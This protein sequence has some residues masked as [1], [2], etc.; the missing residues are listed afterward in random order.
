MKA[1]KDEAAPEAAPEQ[2]HSAAPIDPRLVRRAQATKTYMISGVVVGSLTAVLVLTQAKLLSNSI[3]SVFSTHTLNG[4]G[5]TL[6][7]LAAVLVGRGVLAWASSWLAQRTSAAVKSQLRNDILSARLAAPAHQ[8]SSSSTLVTLVTQ[9]LD[10]LDGYFSKYLPQ[11]L[12]AVTVPVI[13]GAAILFSD[14]RSALIIAATIPF[15]P[16]LMALVG[17][18]TEKQVSRRWAYQARLASHFADLVSGLPTLQVF[19]RAKAQAEGLK[20]TEDAN[21]RETM[22]ILR[23]SFLS[24]FVL[25]LFSTLAVAVIALIIGTRLVYGH[26]DFSTALFV[27]ILAPEVYLPIRQVGVHYHDSADGLAAAEAAFAEIDRAGTPSED[28]ADATPSGAANAR[29][30]PEDTSIIARGLTYTYPGA[31]APIGPFDLTVR[32]GEIVALSGRSGGGKTTLLNCVLGFLTPD[33]SGSLPPVVPPKPGSPDMTATSSATG[34][35]LVADMGSA[36]RTVPV[37]DPSLVAATGTVPVAEP[38]VVPASSPVILP[39]AGSP[40]ALEADCEPV[41]LL[42]GQDARRIDWDVWRRGIAYVPQVPGM[43]DGTIADNVRLGC[44]EATDDQ[45][46]QVLTAAGAG[47]LDPD[48]NVGEEGEGLSVGERRRV[49]IA[50]ALARIDIAGAR[51][52]ILDE[53]T[54]GLD[55]DTEAT[56]LSSLKESGA[57]AL[58][59]SHREAVWASATRVVEI[60][61]A[62]LHEQGS[63]HVLASTGSPESSPFGQSSAHDGG[64]PAFGRMTEGSGGMT[65]GSGGTAGGSGGAA[66]GSGTPESSPFGQSFAHDSGDPA[67]GGM[68]EGSGRMTEGPGGTAGGSGRMTKEAFAESS[69]RGGEIVRLSVPDSV[70]A[71]GGGGIPPRQGTT[72]PENNLSSTTEEPESTSTN[73]KGSPLL[74]L[75]FSLLD[76]VKGSK[77]RLF[78]AIIFA[79]FASAAAVCLMGVS[80]WLIS[81]AAQHPPFLELSVAAVGVRFFGISRGVFRYIERLVGHDVALSMQSALRLKTYQALARTTLLGRRQGDLLV[82]VVSDVGAIEDIVVR[83]VQPF[84]AA[85]LVVAGVC[86]M[87]ARFSVAAALVI[88]ASAILGGLI[89]PWLTGRVSLRADEAAVPLR[90]ELGVVVHNLARNAVDLTAYGAQSRALARMG[91]IDLALRRTEERSAWAQ[92]IGAGLQT[93]A[94][95]IGFIGGLWIG[96]VAVANGTMG[97]RLLAVLVLTPLALHEVFSSFSQAAQTWTRAKVALARVTAIL[98]APPVGHGDVEARDPDETPSLHC[99][100]L[101]IGWPGHPPVAS[102]LDLDLAPGQAVGVMGPSGIG[103]TTLAATI[104][105]LIPPVG[106]E[107]ATTGRIGYL[108]QDAHIFTTTIA[109]NVRIGNKD[110]TDLEVREALAEAGLDVDPDRE[111]GEMGVGLSGGEARRLALARLFVGDYRLL[112]L[113]EPTEHL[114]RET[115]DALMDD[116]FDGVAR[117]PVLVVSHDES[118]AARCDRV[119]VMG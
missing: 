6:G 75:V 32:P 92:G 90:G 20:R 108:A 24:A 59:V 42:G 11:L 53:P 103:K 70:P 3:A 14:W 94:A 81:K 49:G 109:E 39:Q 28:P 118:V 35:V 91:E 83:I 23:I 12:L 4:L 10:A 114:D 116:I 98:D 107:L 8:T 17:W 69:S 97:D 19:G 56:V 89:V 13:I 41:L 117:R 34:T 65:G 1:T 63:A 105:G 72:A 5:L 84:L 26:M 60:G 38:S 100:D 71:P 7:L 27:L 31:E 55:T 68:T 46:R 25:E 93:I 66:G 62:S 44:P 64:D 29:L 58:V 78:W 86:V 101:V 79:A 104:M 74:R 102:G 99:E 57:T 85:S 61:P 119:L 87:L 40:D 43:I 95:G 54:A 50:R 111:V 36:T 51:L 82:R 113:D 77:M 112:I 15:I 106:G 80:A 2:R 115:A 48:R 22:A 67:F 16:V 76:S 88:L 52:L 30:L 18:T 45:V 96:S 110:A 21:R 73:H 33:P 47:N 37:A 9:G